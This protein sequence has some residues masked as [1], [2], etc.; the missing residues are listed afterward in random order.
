MRL[1]LLRS[2]P[3]S[4]LTILLIPMKK[5]GTSTELTTRIEHSINNFFL[6]QWM[7]KFQYANSILRFIDSFYIE[8]NIFSYRIELQTMMMERREVEQ[9]WRDRRPD[10]CKDVCQR[11]WGEREGK[12]YARIHPLVADRA[13]LPWY[14]LSFF[15]TFNTLPG[16][17]N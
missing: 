7:Y 9:R 5:R 2:L 3:S 17:G 8:M 11:M 4:Y 13:M 10:R 15:T 1:H 12:T 16:G 6:V 14:S